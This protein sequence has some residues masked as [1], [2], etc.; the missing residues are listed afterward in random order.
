LQRKIP[1]REDVELT[2]LGLPSSITLEKPFVIQCEIA[3]RSEKTINAKL[4][5]LRNKMSGIL[6]NGIS[7]QTLGLMTPSTNK[8]ITLTLFPLKPGM[9]KIT[10]I[11]IIDTNA[12]D[13]KYD[14]ENL[15]TVL[16][17]SKIHDAQ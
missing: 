12:N 15:S 13:K 4:I 10:G 6:V 1:H 7:G 17:L 11:Q 16:V 8:T 9:Q 5:L 14:F 2:L 3:N